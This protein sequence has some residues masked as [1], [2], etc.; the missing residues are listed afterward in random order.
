MGSNKLSVGADRFLALQW[1]NYAYDLFVSTKGQ[2]ASRKELHNYLENQMVG[3][4][5]TRKTANQL[6]RLWLQSDD[7]YE[8]L[9]NLALSIL[10]PINAAQM[11]VLHLGMAINVFPIYKETV[12]VIGTLERITD[13]I[14]TKSISTRVMEKF[15]TTSSIPRSVTR[16]LQTLNDWHLVEFSEGKVVIRELHLQDPKIVNWFILALLK[17]TGQNE[18]TLSELENC[19]FK[20]GIIFAHPRSVINESDGLILSRNHLGAE[21][22]RIK[23]Q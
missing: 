19:P 23:L 2:E 5:S 8:T 9:R 18:S 1:A 12:R 11:P 7:S 21:V 14:P 6:E 16:V 17:A 15:P 4:V 22:V 13:K 3:Q 10:N 20:L